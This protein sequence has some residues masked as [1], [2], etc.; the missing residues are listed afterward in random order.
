MTP[1]AC[2]LA[3]PA[4]PLDRSGYGRK[5]SAYLHRK[6]TPRPAFEEGGFFARLTSEQ[7]P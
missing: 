3:D 7:R 4:L 2:Q 1:F 6:R 5:L